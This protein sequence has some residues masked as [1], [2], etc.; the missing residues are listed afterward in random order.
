[1]TEIAGTREGEAPEMWKQTPD[2]IRAKEPRL[3]PKSNYE[4]SRI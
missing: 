1:M 3:Y 4:S 2:H